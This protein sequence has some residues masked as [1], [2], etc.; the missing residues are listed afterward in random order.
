[1]CFSRDSSA[2]ESRILFQLNTT[3]REALEHDAFHR[4]PSLI[5]PLHRTYVSFNLSERYDGGAL[6]SQKQC[7][8]I[9]ARMETGVA[10]ELEGSKRRAEMS[11]SDRDRGCMRLVKSDSSQAEISIPVSRRPFCCACRRLQGL[12]Q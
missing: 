4:V 12:Y 7:V 3:I 8:V 5:G 6:G 9:M 2:L 11:V 10:E 1:M